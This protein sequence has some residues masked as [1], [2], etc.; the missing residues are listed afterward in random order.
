MIKPFSGDFRISQEFGLTAYAKAHP[1]IYKGTGGIH[2]GIDWAC[3]SG[4]PILAAEIGTVVKLGDRGGYGKCI[5][6][7]HGGGV[8]TLYAHLSAYKTLLGAKTTQGSTIALSGNT[9]A[10][11]ASH[12]HWEVKANNKWVDPLPFINNQK[13][14]HTRLYPDKDNIVLEVGGTKYPIDTPRDLDNM[15]EGAKLL[16]E[17]PPDADKKPL[18]KRLSF[19]KMISFDDTVASYEKELAKKPKEIEVIKERI[20]EVPIITEVPV[21]V[22]KEIRVLSEDLSA[23][24]LFRLALKKFIGK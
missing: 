24:E 15:F 7:D 10:S 16:G 3:P 22:I 20:K 9:G 1:E 2:S 5:E 17:T 6:I 19:D 14:M 21:E 4:T 18:G 11:T 23:I 8:H 13:E 12:L